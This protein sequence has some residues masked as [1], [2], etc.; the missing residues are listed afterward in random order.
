MDS[1]EET[2]YNT[3]DS[4]NESSRDD[5]HDHDDHNDFEVEAEINSSAEKPTKLD[6][7]IFEVLSTEEIVQH[8]V[9]TI[10]EVSIIMEIPETTARILLNHFKWDKGMLMERFY[11]GDEDRLFSEA[12]VINPFL[13]PTVVKRPKETSA[14]DAEE[15][16]ICFMIVPSPMLT[17]LECGHRFCTQC[18]VEYLNTKIMQEGLG[19]TISC[20]AHRCDILVDDA[21]VMRLVR[22]SKVK[23]KYQRLITNSFVVCSQFLRW[24]PSPKCNNAIKVHYME[25]RPVTCKCSHTFCLAC[26]ENCHE[27][28]KCNLLW[29]WIKNNDNVKAYEWMA[30]YTKECP[31]CNVSIEKNGGCNHMV[32]TNL[33]CKTSFCWHCLGLW[34]SHIGYGC[35]RYVEKNFETGREQKNSEAVLKRQFFYYTRYRSHKQSL[36]FEQKLYAPLEEK[37]KEMQHRGIPWFDVKF[38]KETHDILCQCRQTLMYSCIFAHCLR[39]N[40][41]FLIFAENQKDLESATESLSEYLERD[42]TSENVADIRPKLTDKYIYCERRRK[43]LLEHVNEGYENDWWEFTE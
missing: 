6:P 7:Y 24:C 8:M 41:Q 20:A 27:P 14:A 10:N 21:T 3:F 4:G 17:G 39:E 33:N 9:D 22:D 11:D 34:N 42:I 40:N 28:I 31:N 38:L 23:L 18:W 1:E 19:Q 35:N 29:K 26:G 37:M 43:I 13:K 5:D 16:E 25:A 30:N 12:H 15:C 2:F 36:M 32:C